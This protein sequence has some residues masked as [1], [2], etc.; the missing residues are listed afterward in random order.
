M[1]GGNESSTYEQ[2]FGTSWKKYPDLRIPF[3]ETPLT[4]PT[5]KIR[6]LP[7]NTNLKMVGGLQ[8]VDTTLKHPESV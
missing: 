6:M 5:N 3:K 2:V 1:P 4:L 7:T 8:Y